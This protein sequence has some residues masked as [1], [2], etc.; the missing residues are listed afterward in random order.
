MEGGASAPPFLMLPNTPLMVAPSDADNLFGRAMSSSEIIEG[1]KELNPYIWADQSYPGGLWWPGGKTDKQTAL[2]F[3]KQKI[4]AITAGPVP[5]F[6]Q[7]YSN[8]NIMAKGW[9]AIFSKAIKSKAVT[10]QA[11]EQKFNVI[12]DVDGDLSDGTCPHCR[13]MGKTTKSTSA[14]GLCDFHCGVQRNVAKGMK[15]KK[16]MKQI[17][18]T[19]ASSNHHV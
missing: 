13:R 8:G 3:K 14:K 7:Q 12:L 18:R 17:G 16:L 6:T 11:I 19:Y 10:K 15:L 9:R 1:L 5:E 4:T 2:W